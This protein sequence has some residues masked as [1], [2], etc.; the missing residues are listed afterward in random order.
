MSGI[1][2]PCLKLDHYRIFALLDFAV[3]AVHMVPEPPCCGYWRAGRVK[4][5]SAHLPG[6]S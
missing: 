2:T 6:A 3:S 5:F 1:T 4:G